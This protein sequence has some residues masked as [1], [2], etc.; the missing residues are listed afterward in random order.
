MRKVFALML[1]VVAMLA[2]GVAQQKK[3]DAGVNSGQAWLA[4]VDSGDYA[5]S[6]DQA[7]GMFKD[8]ITK[9]KWGEAL[10]ASRAPLGKVSSRK[11]LGAKYETELPGAPD[12]EYV[13]M[14]FSSSFDNKKQ[15]VETVTVVL[16]KEGT[17]RAAGYY[18]R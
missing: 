15:A 3:T 2:V 8:A 4:I 9:E 13:V 10:K 7:A 14:Q 12:G 11:L 5:T 1:V 18:I 6:W 16:D 17:W